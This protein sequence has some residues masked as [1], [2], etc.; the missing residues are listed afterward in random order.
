[1]CRL[2]ANYPDDH[3]S[4]VAGRF[5]LIGRLGSG[6]TGD[7]HVA[8][9]RSSH[10]R[11]AIKL[12]TERAR[13]RAGR[14]RMRAEVAAV[15]RLHH[16]GIARLL[17]YDL[18][19]TPPYLVVELVD[20]PDL[21]LAL[22]LV[23]GRF[24]VS[25]AV[26]L[27]SSMLDAVAWAH[28]RG[29]VHGDVKPENVLLPTR[30]GSEVKLTDFGMARLRDRDPGRDRAS[31]GIT[32]AYASPE[33][34]LGGPADERSDLYASGLV[35]Y[36]MLCGRH[37]FDADVPLAF[38]YQH[39]HRP[40]PPPSRF[41]DGLDPNLEELVVG[42]LSKAPER[43]PSSARDVLAALSRFRTVR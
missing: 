36:E 31:L 41:V 42:L 16:P 39:V 9:D 38:L 8:H 3:V 34:A 2:P 14:E 13:A 18:D 21:R 26:A 30:E 1:M 27:M 40:V 24:S 32:A 11:V 5:E 22:D 29:V 37:P 19:A 43:R 23:G 6:G 12:L 28:E 35:L 25:R 33:Q 20:G 10:R 4:V 7:V 17:S 15:S